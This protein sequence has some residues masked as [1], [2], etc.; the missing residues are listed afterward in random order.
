MSDPFAS[1][2]DS[3]SNVRIADFK[4]HLLL[5][6]PT[7]HLEKISTTYGEKDAIVT[8][9][10]VLDRGKDY[11]E[12]TG[13]LVFQGA[14]IGALKRRIGNTKQPMLLGRLGQEQRDKGNPAWVFQPITEDDAIAART[15]LS[16]KETSPWG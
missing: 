16:S 12:Y 1:N 14:L 7:E 9:I 13:V 6:T 8:D 10:V 15:Y 11:E 2:R 4:G 3:S 5:C